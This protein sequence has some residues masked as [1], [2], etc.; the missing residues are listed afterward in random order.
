MARQKQALKRPE[1]IS[2]LI[3]RNQ[4]Y[5]FKWKDGVEEVNHSKFQKNCSDFFEKGKIK[6]EVDGDLQKIYATY[7]WQ[8]GR[9][10]FSIW[11]PDDGW[12]D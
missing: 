3:G 5:F 12:R 4:E 8:N 7:D 2:E 9:E 11:N 6:K 10:I 1:K